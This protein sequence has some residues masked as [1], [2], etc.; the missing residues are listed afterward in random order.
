ML[1]RVV[2]SFEGVNLELRDKKRI[3]G[4]VF[5]WLPCLCAGVLGWARFSGYSGLM[6]VLSHICGLVEIWMT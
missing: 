6:W 2:G 1:K 4:M 3:V 5:T